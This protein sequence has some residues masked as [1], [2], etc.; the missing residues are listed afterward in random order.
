[1]AAE[2]TFGP[3]PQ[4]VVQTMGHIVWVGAA[5]FVVACVTVSCGESNGSSGSPDG[6]ADTSASGSSSGDS[7]ASSGERDS[8][9]SGSS[10]GDGSGSGSVGE[11]G[12]GAEGGGDDSSVQDGAPDGAGGSEGVQCGKVIDAGPTPHCTGGQVCC[13]DND[14]ATSGPATFACQAR[15]VSCSGTVVSCA[16]T[17]DCPQGQLCCG[18][19]VSDFYPAVSCASECIPADGGGVAYEFCD[20]KAPA[21]SGTKTCI[22]SSFLVGYAVCL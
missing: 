12:S 20:L 7:G 10:S 8:S 15:N 1:M 4:K 11:G 5:A 16:S 3:R 21:C 6:G 17:S 9:S 13:V 19:L 14:L 2:L 18:A 22:A